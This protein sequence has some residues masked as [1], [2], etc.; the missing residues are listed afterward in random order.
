[1]IGI[2]KKDKRTKL[3]QQIDKLIEE[4]SQMEVK[5]EKDESHN[6]AARLARDYD[7]KLD[8]IERLHKLRD[9]KPEPK[10]R[11]SPDT[12]AVVAGN[13][14]GIVLILTY[15]KVNVITTKA[16][17]FVLRGRV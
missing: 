5:I 14:L 3:D 13:L 1:M 6:G 2:K 9:E 11:V 15:E 8:V 10:K 4:L 16:L 17:G 7:I 12:I